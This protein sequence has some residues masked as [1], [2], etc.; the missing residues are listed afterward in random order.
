MHQLEKTI[1]E[2]E[3]F[4][5]IGDSSENRFPGYSYNAYTKIGKS[6]YCLDLGG[7]TESR[8]PTKGGKVFTSVEELPD[9]RSD[10]AIIWVKPRSAARAV[11]VAH[12]AGCKRV[13][14]SFQTGHR[15]AVARAREL[16]MEVVEIGRCPVY[17]LDEK[18]GAC[19]MHTFIVRMT[20]AYK[21]PPQIDS[22]AKRRELR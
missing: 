20:G 4:V 11:K 2:A 19:A 15:D 22:E 12:E 21:L 10:L 17:Y 9:D 14:F 3:G 1:R 16:G 18:P 7:L 6:F 13:W 5:L 8:G